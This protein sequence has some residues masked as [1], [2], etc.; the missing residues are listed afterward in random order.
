MSASDW[1]E[2]DGYEA[3]VSELRANPPVAPERLR[4][5]VLEGAP[6]PRRP[7]SRKR[8][9]VLVVVPAA[10]VLAVGAALVHGFVS[11]GSHAKSCHSIMPRLGRPR[12][13]A[14][15]SLS[16]AQHTRR[17][18]SRRRRE[19]KSYNL[20][21]D[22]AGVA[23][24]PL[25]LAG[26][27]PGAARDAVTIPRNR[28]VH[29]VASLQVGVKSSNLSAKTNEASQIVGSFGGYAQSVR[30][31]ATHRGDGE[32]V[33]AL[34]VPVQNAQAAIAK[35]GGARHA[36]L[37][38]GLDAGSAGE[39]HAAE[40]RD[41]LAAAR[42]RRL[43]ER[44]A[45]LDAHRHRAGRHPDQAQQRPPRAR[46]AAARPQRHPRVGRDRR[47]LA[48]A[49]DA[50]P[51]DR[52]A[53]SRREHPHRPAARLGCPLPRAR[54]DHRP[55][56]AHRARS[57][58]P[59]RRRSAGGSCAS[60]GGATSGCSRVRDLLEYGSCYSAENSR[61]ATRSA[62]SSSRRSSSPSRSCRR[63]SCRATS[64]TSRAPTGLSVFAIAS[65]V[66]FVLMIAAVNFFG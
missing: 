22:S 61:S 49:H 64:R 37:A 55:L 19:F 23:S 5:R 41:R 45:E 10:I 17:R 32:A 6:A 21:Q 31:Q 25:A 44:A 1:S 28:L 4:Q 18:G 39:A 63:S 30:Y 58:A 60:G 59:A 13:R 26:V 42:D 15:G 52:G 8:K 38:A 46:A 62:S 12:P 34:R 3:L 36:P 50:E 57:G 51:R 47:H 35:L 9:L 20:T 54:G 16:R 29:A 48:P 2:L 14:A 53:A 27:S 65:V 33:L 7:R 56:R 24:A 11:S 40:Q 66:M 43:R